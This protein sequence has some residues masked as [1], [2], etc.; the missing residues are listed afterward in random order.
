MRLS[1][2]LLLA[3]LLAGLVACATASGPDDESEGPPV[4]E[5][6]CGISDFTCDNGTC[7]PYS[8]RCDDQAQCTDGSDEVGCTPLGCEPHQ[9]RCNDGTCIDPE[10]VCDGLPHCRDNEDEADCGQEQAEAPPACAAG[11]FACDDGGCIPRDWVCDGRYLDCEGGEDE[12][13]A[14]CR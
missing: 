8:A 4:D 2:S 10:K 9:F 13:D 14:L 11:D 1:P 3:P 5:H 6:G 7:I 12:S